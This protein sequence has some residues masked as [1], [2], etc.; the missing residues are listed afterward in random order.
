MLFRRKKLEKPHIN[1]KFLL[2]DYVDFFYKDDLYFGHI[3][4]IYLD[5]KNLVV[6]DIDI[7][8]QCPST[9]DNIYE[10]KVIRIHK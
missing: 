6:Y 7:A 3:S 9:I 8:G 2:G 1:S 10:E 5:E 4:N